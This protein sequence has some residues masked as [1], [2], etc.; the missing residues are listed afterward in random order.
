MES[1]EQISDAQ[2]TG[3]EVQATISVIGPNIVINGNIEGIGDAKNVDLQ[4]EGRVN[5]DVRCSTVVLAETSSIKGNIIADRVRIAGTVEGG[6]Q[7]AELAVEATAVIKGDIVYERIRVVTGAVLNGNIQCRPAGAE[8]AEPG[9]LKLV[10]SPPA[11]RAP[12]PSKEV[13]IE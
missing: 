4:I 1:V 10:E 5:G 6:V 8:A 7:T 3:R 12:E 13:W 2:Q 11:E 9:K